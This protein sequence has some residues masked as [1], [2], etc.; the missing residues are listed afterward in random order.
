M[1]FVFMFLGSI[2]FYMNYRGLIQGPWIDYA[3]KHLLLNL[4][5]S[6]FSVFVI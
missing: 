3:V 6:Y 1:N 5:I 2:I 4:C